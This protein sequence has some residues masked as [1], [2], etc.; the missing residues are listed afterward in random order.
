MVDTKFAG[1]DERYTGVGIEPQPGGRR[2]PLIVQSDGNQAFH[3]Q[4]FIP[5]VHAVVVRV[6]SAAIRRLAVVSVYLGSNRD[7]IRRVRATCE[8]GNDRQG[9]G[10]GE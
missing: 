6:R 3:D 5:C 4:H 9:E 7:A 2:T 8:R 10:Q 1:I